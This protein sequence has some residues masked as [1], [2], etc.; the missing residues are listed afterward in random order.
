[1]LFISLKRRGVQGNDM[2]QGG[3]GK[4][5]QSRRKIRRKIGKKSRQKIK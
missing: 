3:G 4:R 1:M 5:T 2:R